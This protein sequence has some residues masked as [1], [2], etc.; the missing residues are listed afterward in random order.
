MWLGWLLFAV[1]ALWVIPPGLIQFFRQ[2]RPLADAELNDDDQR[3]VSVIMP[4]RNEAVCIEQAVRSILASEGIHLEL[5]VVNDRSTDATGAILD[6]LATEDDRIRVVHIT[7]LPSGWL[8]KNHAMHLAAETAGGELLLFTDGDIIF[9]PT[10]IAAAVHH[11][12]ERG[13]DHVTLLPRMVHGSLPESAAIAF[14]GLAFVIGVQLPLIRT[15][16]PLSYAGVGAFNLL[17]AQRYRSFGG[18]LPLRL[19]VLDDM[20]LGRLVKLSGGRQDLLLAS[21]LLSVRWQPSFWGVVTGLE[22]N[23]FASLGYS[24]WRVMA[25]TVAFFLTMLLPYYWAITLAWPQSSGFLATVL[26]WHSVFTLAAVHAGGSWMVFPLFPLGALTMAFAFWRST[27]ITL[28]NGGVT[29]RDS[30]YPLADL[31]AA[32]SVLPGEACGK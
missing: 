5:I 29:W 10:A 28:R 22:K 32:Q 23:G 24:V 26:L 20:Q 11:L 17:T 8:G 14:F 15:R 16:F 12:R 27:W 9:Q 6:R 25:A 7:E 18:H 31:R 1:V 3:L 19:N 2:L 30:F 21:D 4:A 13:L